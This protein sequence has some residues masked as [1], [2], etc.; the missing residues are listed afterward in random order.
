M[1]PIGMSKV[2][3]LPEKTVKGPCCCVWACSF[4]TFLDQSN[5]GQVTFLLSAV[6]LTPKQDL[7][8]LA[9]NLRTM[10]P[11]IAPGSAGESGGEGQTGAS[12]TSSEPSSASTLSLSEYPFAGPVD[13]SPAQKEK[14]SPPLPEQEGHCHHPQETLH[15]TGPMGTGHSAK[16]S[17]QEYLP[18][19]PK[20]L[21][22]IYRK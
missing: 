3:C 8:A 6:M 4:L 12:T 18:S 10:D 14:T 15:P 20:R 9:Q 17:K 2:R 21:H 16:A 7:R 1:R 13:S 19:W 5:E 11:S 22:R